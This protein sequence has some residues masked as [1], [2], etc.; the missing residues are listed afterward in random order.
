M[1]ETP[2]TDEVDTFM[3]KAAEI[4]RN[5][6]YSIPTFLAV[7]TVVGGGAMISLGQ[8]EQRK[9]N[10]ELSVERAA[11]G[12][13]YF[14]AIAEISEQPAILET[15]SNVFEVDG[16]D[17]YGQSLEHL[18]TI[19]EFETDYKENKELIDATLLESTTALK[20]YHD[21]DNIAITRLVTDTE[22]AVYITQYVT[23]DSLSLTANEWLTRLGSLS[24]EPPEAQVPETADEIPTPTTR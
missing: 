8:E 19:P 12:A 24:A 3:S 16:I 4:A 1:I 20:V 23:E 17:L 13:H 5:P 15:A 2:H 18:E 11:Q 9:S 14:K 7:A 10:S 21:G 22:S 6:R